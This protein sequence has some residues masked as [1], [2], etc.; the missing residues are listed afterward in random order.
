MSTLNST[1]VR[2]RSGIALTTALALSAG[3]S[4]LGASAASAAPTQPPIDTS[5]FDAGRY[6]VVLDQDP[7][8]TYRGGLPNLARTAPLGTDDIDLDT[9]AAD[10]YA[11]HLESGA[12]AVASAIGAQIASSL[13]VTMNG[14]IADP[15]R[16]RRSS[17]ARDSRVSQ[18][19]PDEIQQIQASPANEY[20]DLKGLWDAGRRRGRRG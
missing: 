7:L 13:T 19:F 5:G 12:G 8:A 6:I 1:R 20:L 17:C 9:S 3:A 11:A 10:A 16:S 4:V 18:I 15:R 14:F 2:L